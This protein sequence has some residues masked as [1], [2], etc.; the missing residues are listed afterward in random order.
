VKIIKIVL[1]PILLLSLVFAN[2]PTKDDFLQS[3]PKDYNKLL[4]A[5]ERVVDFAFRWKALYEQQKQ[6]N[7]ELMQKMEVMIA[8][9]EE[10]QNSINRMEKTIDTLQTIILKLLGENKLSVLGLYNFQSGSLSIGI[11][12]KF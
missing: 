9:M 4:E 6:I 8:K 3:A 7:D 1:V 5:Y 11:G 12:Y 2:E 10:M